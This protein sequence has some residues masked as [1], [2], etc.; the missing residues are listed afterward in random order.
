MKRW[1]LFTDGACTGN[2]GPGGWAFI[3]RDV[4]SGGEIEESGGEA[5]TTNNR[6]EM[7]AAIQGLDRLA[8]PCAVDLYADSQYLVNGLREWIDRWKA[9][10]WRRGKNEAV[11]NLDLWRRLDALRGRHRIS[12]IWV[13]GHANHDENERC[14]RLAT[15]AAAK[16][17]EAE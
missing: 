12:P 8:E 9:K 2:P 5:M 1:Q 13:R 16:A 17:G 6:M 11:A 14:D 10:G 7:M 15:A 4:A 3:L